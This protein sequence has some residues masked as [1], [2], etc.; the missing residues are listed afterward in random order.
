M[1][2]HSARDTCDVSIQQAPICDPP[3]CRTLVPWANKASLAYF[4]RS[5]LDESQQD[6]EEVSAA[7]TCDALAVESGAA[8]GDADLLVDCA[9]LE[10]EEVELAFL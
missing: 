2:D 7:L 4:R 10:I 9:E 5:L 1:S 3:H 6:V 8:A